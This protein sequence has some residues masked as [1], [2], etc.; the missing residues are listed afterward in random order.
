ML[1]SI[2]PV[3][4]VISAAE[5]Y[6]YIV[7]KFDNKFGVNYQSRGVNIANYVIDHCYRKFNSYKSVIKVMTKAQIDYCMDATNSNE[8]ARVKD[9]LYAMHDKE[10]VYKA[11]YTG[12][13][14]NTVNTKKYAEEGMVTV[15]L[16][17]NIK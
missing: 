14:A 11:I 10:N 3:Q 9:V 4:E 7:T 13:S 2:L 6:E 8:S 5:L 1:R 15:W 16:S 12:S 17:E